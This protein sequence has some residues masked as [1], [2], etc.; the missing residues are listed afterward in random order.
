MNDLAHDIGRSQLERL[1]FIEQQL[2][3][4][5]CYTS[6]MLIDTFGV[7]KALAH[8][9]IALYKKSFPDN[10]APFDPKLGYLRP[11]STFACQL[12]D[13]RYP[14]GE[15]VQQVPRLAK[16]VSGDA[17]ELI[18]KAIDQSCSIEVNYA[19][20][21]N[22]IGKKRL[23]TPSKI[24]NASNR[25]HFRGFCH[26]NNDYRDF[27][28]ARCQTLPK[29][30]V[31]PLDLPPDKELNETV[32]VTLKVNEALCDDGRRVVEKEYCDALRQSI[33]L[34]RALFHYFLIDNNLPVSQEQI[35]LS[36]RVPWAYPLLAEAD[37][38]VL[39]FGASDK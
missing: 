2:L 31:T 37:D 5:R 6:N 9:D 34:P 15:L 7:S 8:K 1:K 38:K 10:V 25:L 30:K 26:S 21:N 4:G 39:L 36:R 23:I 12:V 17:L 29:L 20:S 22:P 18:L 19:S 11:A 16:T 24:I 28:V 35:D 32:E 3:W 27:V 14:P 33:H 13:P